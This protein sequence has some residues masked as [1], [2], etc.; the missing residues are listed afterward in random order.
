MAIVLINGRERRVEQEQVTY[1]DL[2]V[3]NSRKPGAYSITYKQG[4]KRGKILPS[5]PPLPVK[6]GLAIDIMIAGAM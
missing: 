4:K 3:L 5:S 2:L 1:D 6:A